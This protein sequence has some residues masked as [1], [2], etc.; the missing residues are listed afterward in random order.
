MHLHGFP[1]YLFAIFAMPA[2][3]ATLYFQ[4]VVGQRLFYEDPL[5]LKLRF[6][7]RQGEYLFHRRDSFGRSAMIALGRGSWYVVRGTWFVD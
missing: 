1:I 4:G 3:L 5:R 2:N 6:D 7:L